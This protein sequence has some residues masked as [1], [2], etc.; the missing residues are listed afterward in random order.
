MTLFI[1]VLIQQ[2]FIENLVF[3]KY[4]TNIGSNRDV[5]FDLAELPHCRGNRY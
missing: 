4:S 2:L 3:P 5:V 1:N